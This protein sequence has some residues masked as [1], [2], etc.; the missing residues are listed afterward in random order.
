MKKEKEECV[1]RGWAGLR[2][3]ELMWISSNIS[4]LVVHFITLMDEFYLLVCDWQWQ[5]SPNNS[6]RD[7]LPWTINH[8]A[9]AKSQP[10]QPQGAALPRLTSAITGYIMPLTHTWVIVLT[11]LC[12]VLPQYLFQVPISTSY[13]VC[14]DKRGPVQY[15]S[16]IFRMWWWL[17]T[18]W[19]V[20]L[21][22]V[23]EHT[24]QAIEALAAILVYLS[25]LHFLLP[26]HDGLTKGCILL[27]KG[28]ILPT[29][30]HFC[31]TM[32]DSLRAVSYRRSFLAAKA[33]KWLR[34][35]FDTLWMKPLEWC[36]RN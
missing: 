13:L 36:L 3:F 31:Q 9:N 27:T 30:G 4:L 34:G 35:K 33:Q 32:M 26:N 21:A 7:K 28:C 19:F 11:S 18:R 14:S 17:M 15:E 5:F 29:G 8:S 16:W 1:S 12:I 25:M 24:L 2:V 22:V 23:V 20:E 10:D 6:S